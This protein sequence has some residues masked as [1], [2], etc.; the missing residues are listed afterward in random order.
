MAKPRIWQV[1]EYVRVKQGAEYALI[2]LNKCLNMREYVLITLNMIEY[3][4]ICLKKQ[5]AEYGRYYILNGKFNSKKET[6][7]T[8]LS[9]INTLFSIFKKGKGAL[10][11]LLLS[12]PPSLRTCDCG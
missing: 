3:V 11:F 12:P 7:S 9:K 10:P 1:Y 4:G 2:S 6:I 8:F 5:S